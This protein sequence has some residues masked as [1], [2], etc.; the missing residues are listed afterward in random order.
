M[1]RTSLSAALVL[2]TGLVLAPPASAAVDAFLHLDGIEGESTD[3]K[4][5]GWIEVSSFQFEQ[6]R[7]AATTIGSATGGAGSGRTREGKVSVHDI[8]I[9][10]RV[11]KA[12][13]SLFKHCAN[14]VHIANG[15][16]SMRKAGGTQQEYLVIKLTDIIVSSYRTVGA[17]AGGAGAT[18]T[19]TLNAGNAMVEYTGAPTSP[20]RSAQLAP[21]SAALVAKSPTP[22][23]AP[24][25]VR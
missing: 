18:E 8:S 2:A 16:I 17:G 23:P 7:S 9:T 13:P 22:T 1:K 11:D 14:G 19:F 10:K 25:A 20:G 4:H 12:T 5:K 15:Q 3:A 24:K 6:V 21:G